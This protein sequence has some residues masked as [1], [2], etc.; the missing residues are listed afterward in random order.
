M[1]LI[2]YSL[3]DLKEE[4]INTPWLQA[5]LGGISNDGK[6]VVEIQC[7]RKIYNAVKEN[8]YLIPKSCK[9][10]P[11]RNALATKL[12]SRDTR[13]ALFDCAL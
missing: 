1:D 12:H 7:G 13:F 11:E 9:R 2:S 8:R 6:S 3:V 5:S 10:S 4:N